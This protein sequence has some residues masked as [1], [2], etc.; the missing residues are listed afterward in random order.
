[1]LRR[2][3]FPTGLST[4]L[5]RPGTQQQ[6]SQE[7]GS[8]KLSSVRFASARSKV[9]DV[10][11]ICVD[12]E[13]GEIFSQEAQEQQPPVS[14]RVDL[15]NSSPSPAEATT[16]SF[17]QEYDVLRSA[18]QGF[19]PPLEAI[20]E[21]LLRHPQHWWCRYVS[22]SYSARWCAGREQQGTIDIV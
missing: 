21:L 5:E 6:P 9:M 3:L 4:F 15:T 18:A 14:V 11:V 7:R 17:E 2:I 13:D 19:E 1:M 16:T 10:E 20:A 22:V 12:D 8:G